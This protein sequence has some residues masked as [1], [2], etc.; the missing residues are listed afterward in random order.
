MTVSRRDFL[1]TGTGA[2][3]AL[4]VG[5]TPALLAQTADDSLA[6]INGRIHTLD[7]ANTVAQSVVIRNGKFVSV[8]GAMGSPQEL[9]PSRATMR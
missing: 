5:S 6:L 9:T 8:N 4:G 1:W 7:A 3:L 2:A